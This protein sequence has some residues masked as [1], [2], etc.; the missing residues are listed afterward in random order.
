MFSGKQ[1]LRVVG[2]FAA[3]ATLA[4]NV[5]CTGFFVNPTVT[6]L[7][8][9][10]ANLSLA[11]DTSFQ[12]V[13]TATYSDG[14]TSDVTGKSVWTS[15]SPNVASFSSPGRLTATSLSNLTTLPGT[16]SVSASDG[17]VSSSQQT[18]TVCPVVQTMTLT[19][20]NG[21][22]VT[23]TG[24]EAVQFDVVATFNGVSGTTDVTAFATWNISN[25]AVLPSIDINGSGTTTAGTPSTI[26]VSATLCGA[27]SKTVNVTTTS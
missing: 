17:T 18:V 8:I 1:K 11:P 13:A 4:L 2:A 9:G 14:S 26:T 25:T 21:A 20:N 6:S 12:M 27:T 3:L 5:S 7:A 19:V 23:V 24:G 10:P 22:S 15:S 16:T